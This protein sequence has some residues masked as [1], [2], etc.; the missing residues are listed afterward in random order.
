MSLTMSRWHGP[1]AIGVLAGFSAWVLAGEP[2]AGAFVA[3]LV[4]VAAG[5]VTQTR[6]DIS[7]RSYYMTGGA[8]LLLLILMM[9]AGGRRGPTAWHELQLEF[10]TDRRPPGM[11][12]RPQVHLIRRT[13]R[14][15]IT[16]YRYRRVFVAVGPDGIDLRPSWPQTLVYR[17]LHIPLQRLVRCRTDQSMFAGNTLV[18]VQYPM[19]DVGLPDADGRVMA[20]CHENRVGDEEPASGAAE[21]ASIRD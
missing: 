14:F 12:R 13:S 8:V 21:G 19:V 2:A 10:T 4:A 20:W 9:K 3:L 11:E 15:T 6:T 18:E 1:L 5:I 7:V 16:P 17:S